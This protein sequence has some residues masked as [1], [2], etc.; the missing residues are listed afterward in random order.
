[1]REAIAEVAQQTV[2]APIER[3]LSEFARFRDELAVARAAI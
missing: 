1:M 2:L 3:E